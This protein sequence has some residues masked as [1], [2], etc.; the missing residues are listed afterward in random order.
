MKNKLEDDASL[1]Y[2]ENEVHAFFCLCF[3]GFNTTE[4]HY[5]TQLFSILK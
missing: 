1:S 4:W 3:T 2:K 5:A